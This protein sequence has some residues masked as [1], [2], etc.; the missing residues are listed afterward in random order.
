MAK[1]IGRKL[2]ASNRRARH[3]YTILDTYEAGVV[4]V[5]TEVKTL[6]DGKA[7]LVD[8]FGQIEHG[9][10]YLHH[11]HIPE[12]SQGSWTNHT[13]RRTRKLLLHAREIDKI[14]NTMRETGLT[15]VP[16]SMYFKDGKVK[17][18]IGVG[19]GKKLY[20]KRQDMAK[21]DADRE[22]RRATARH[23]KGMD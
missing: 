19:R 7:N 10:V 1:E 3:D 9:E 14:T 18:E 4:L 21:R 13:P 2:I 12:Y 6:R 23:S 11:L 15:L 20:D 22:M 16:M 5:G 8:A 17:V